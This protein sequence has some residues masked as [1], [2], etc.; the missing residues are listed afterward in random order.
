MTPS[1]TA[2]RNRRE[3]PDQTRETILQAAYAEFAD[4]GKAGASMRAIARR[5]DCVQSLISHHFGSKDE[6]WNTVTGRITDD[7]LRD[8]GPL[9]DLEELTEEDL[10]QLLMKLWE[11]WETNP[12]ALRMASWR[13]LEADPGEGVGPN[14]AGFQRFH[15]A[16][17]RG[18]SNG[19]V[20]RDVP[21][22]IALMAVYSTV[23]QACL[24]AHAIGEPS[25][26]IITA[27]SIVDGL[28]QLLK[29]PAA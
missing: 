22:T 21:A 9:L 20:R 3:T 4:K 7:W 12:A 27:D 1:A 25:K 23:M 5:A 6:L 18:Q 8:G 10:R 24:A 14:S 19:L 13:L 11:F 16:I 15:A 29:A 26:A 28:M 2:R 17:L